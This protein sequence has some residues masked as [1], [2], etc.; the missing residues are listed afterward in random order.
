MTDTTTMWASF[1]S[2]PQGMRNFGGV[3]MS[4]FCQ[5]GWSLRSMRSSLSVTVC[6]SPCIVATAMNFRHVMGGLF[7]NWILGGEGGADGSRVSAGWGKGAKARCRAW[8]RALYMSSEMTLL[9]CRTRF[10]LTDH[11]TATKEFSSKSTSCSSV[12]CPAILP[13]NWVRR[14]MLCDKK[15]RSVTADFGR[16][17]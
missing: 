14:S 10:P 9:K 7:S 15:R 3:Q 2:S 12:R 6:L 11:R 4:T 5:A 1:R 16:L 13:R 17:K 8:L